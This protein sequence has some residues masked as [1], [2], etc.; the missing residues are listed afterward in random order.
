[1]A[2]IRPF[3]PRGRPAPAADELLEHMEKAA[4]RFDASKI[5]GDQIARSGGG[6][7]AEA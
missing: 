4:A 6:G 7:E 5:R 3:R 2:R 1:V